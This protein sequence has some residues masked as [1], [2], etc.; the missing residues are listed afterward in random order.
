MSKFRFA[1]TNIESRQEGVIESGSFDEAVL[2][3]AKHVTVRK[4]DL[5]EIGVHG[6]PPAHY[7]CVGSIVPG[8]PVW[9]PA[10]A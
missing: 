10:A 4:G 8:E 5:L 1:L 3:L 9:M 7:E 2:T 6:F